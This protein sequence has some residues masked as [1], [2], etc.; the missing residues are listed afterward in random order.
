ML[1]WYWIPSVEAKGLCRIIFTDDFGLI[2][3]VIEVYVVHDDV[4]E[5]DDSGDYR[6]DG[7]GKKTVLIHCTDAFLVAG[8]HA[9][10][11]RFWVLENTIHSAN[12]NINQSSC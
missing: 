2:E 9:I 3:W 8:D 7:G 4:V 12:N 11:R 5:R 6:E 1:Q 10:Q